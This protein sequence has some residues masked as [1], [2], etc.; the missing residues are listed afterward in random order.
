MPQGLALQ[1]FI[2]Y[3]YMRKRITILAPVHAQQL[4]ARGWRLWR[5]RG[6]ERVMGDGSSGYRINLAKILR[7]I[8]FFVPSFARFGL[9]AKIG[10]SVFLAGLCADLFY[11]KLN[12]AL[13]LLKG[14]LSFS[15]EPYAV[16]LI[17]KD[18]LKTAE[19]YI[20]FY[21]SIPGVR[22]SGEMRELAEKARSGRSGLDGLLHQG[23]HAL[24]GIKGEESDEFIAQATDVAV[25]FTG[26]GDARDLYREYQN[27]ANGREVDKLSAGLAAIGLT[28]SLG[29]MAGTLG[30]IVTGGTS[31]A[32]AIALCEPV[33]N[34]ALGIKKAL[35]FMN[36]KLKKT[37]QKLFEPVF[38]MI[39]DARLLDHL[40][41]MSETGKWKKF[42]KDN[43]GKISDIAKL[44]NSKMASLEDIVKLARKDPKAAKLVVESASDLKSL[45]SLSKMALKLGDSGRDIFKFGGKNAIEA[46]ET[47]NRE[48]KL[49]AKTL[50]QSMRV[51]E[52]GL[53]AVARGCWRSLDRMLTLINKYAPL[54]WWF[55]L[56]YFLAKIP[57]LLALAAEI[58]GIAVLLKT[59]GL[60]RLWLQKA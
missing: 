58:L 57:L 45:S 7:T 17:E 60:Q 29:E 34:L 39:A 59:W 54:L 15:P 43:I 21:A 38:K 56:Q 13:P 25:D 40:P 55:M 26:V 9:I 53:K 31:T 46:M 2:Y 14:A 6:K 48:G 32:S 51:G 28:M 49:S 27:Y 5:R 10:I 50:K 19:E 1:N 18:H 16:A 37:A 52:N 24:K 3:N 33:K 35:K 41:K 23:R 42:L 11:A 47:L 20:N 36:P 12:P 8:W 44:A 30:G 22:L 4:P